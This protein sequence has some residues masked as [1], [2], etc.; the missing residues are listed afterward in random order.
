MKRLSAFPWTELAILAIGSFL[1]LALRLSLILFESGDYY[2]FFREWY[3]AFQE[4]GFAAVVSLNYDYTPTYLYLLY[5]VSTFLPKLIPVAA[6]K[7]PSIAFDF[8]SAW[9][10]FRIVRL[11]YPDG[12]APFFAY[13]V[14]LFAPKIVLN[15]AVWGQSESIFT[16]FLLLSIYFLLTD[17]NV[18][19]SLAFGVAFVLKLQA[20]FLLPL[21][22]ALA[23][24]RRFAWKH[25]LWIT[26]VYLFLMIPAWFAGRPMDELLMIYLEQSRSFSALTL[27]SPTVYAWLPES[28]FALFYPAGVIWATAMV[29]LYLLAVFKSRSH[30]S[31]ALVMNLALLAVLLTPFF[32]P[33]MHER[34]F[35]PADMLAIAYGFFFPEHYFIPIAMGAV[36]L[37]AYQP[38]LFG[39]QVIPGEILA[40]GVLLILVLVTRKALLALYR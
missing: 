31:Q 15:R 37:F 26:L 28:L 11:K 14:V 30:L 12:P 24:N 2:L 3:R 38:F 1:A 10:V 39:R 17:H 36:S 18:F 23:L 27:N 22:L 9:L 32:L 19:A 4:Q 20:I 16:T 13:F 34:Y 35:Y 40:F 29:F 6:I 5:G 21:L 33:K 25:F 7:L 8:L